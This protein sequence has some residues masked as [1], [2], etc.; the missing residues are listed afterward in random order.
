M[1]LINSNLKIYRLEINLLPATPIE[2][3]AG[4]LFILS[5]GDFEISDIEKDSLLQGEAERVFVDDFGKIDTPV[6]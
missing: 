1:Q 2:R 6:Q 5:F 4:R 3:G